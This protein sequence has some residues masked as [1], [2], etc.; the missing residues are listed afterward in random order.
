MASTKPKPAKSRKT[1]KAA[2]E[3][4]GAVAL[5]KPKP[6]CIVAMGNSHISYMHMNLLDANRPMIA[7]HEIWGINTM[8]T[9][10]RCDRAFHIDPLG[11]YIDGFTIPKGSMS[12]YHTTEEDV[13][14]EP[15]PVMA[16]RYQELDVPIY[17]G[18]PDPRFPTSVAFPLEEVLGM[19]SLPYLNSTVAYAVA[20]AVYEKRPEIWMFGCD[21]AYPNQNAGEAGRACT[22]YWLG[23][24]SAK[25]IKVVTAGRCVL[26]D[27]WSDRRELYGYGG[28]TIEEIRGG[29]A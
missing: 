11:D 22:E 7:D 13:V 21:Y 18:V 19:V 20:L 14:V 26:L 5:S 8:S 28:K 15:D 27:S 24:A 23:F 25:G 3:K 10:I 1:S 6:V 17:T 16:K 12:G 9:V 29:D 4:S 2:P